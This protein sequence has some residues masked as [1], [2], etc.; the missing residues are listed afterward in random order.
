MYRKTV[1]SRWCM[2]FCA[3]SSTGVRRRSI[4]LK[5]LDERATYRV[6]TIDN[7]LLNKA[8]SFSGSYLM[9]HGIDLRT[10]GDYDSTSIAFERE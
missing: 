3:R 9:H 7:K 2:R 1:S 6:R 10:A 8:A 5:G 4:Y